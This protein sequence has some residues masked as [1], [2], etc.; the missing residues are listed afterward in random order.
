M[1]ELCSCI[2]PSL[3][4]MTGFCLANSCLTVSHSCAWLDMFTEYVHVLGSRVVSLEMFGYCVMHRQF[5]G[6]C[7][8]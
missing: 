2:N 1:K 6:I 5:R 3:Q 4:L 8:T 7:A